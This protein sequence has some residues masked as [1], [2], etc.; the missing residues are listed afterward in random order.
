MLDNIRF[1]QRDR[2][3]LDPLPVIN[4]LSGLIFLLAEHPSPLIST[5]EIISP[6]Y[7]SNG[8]KWTFDIDTFNSQLFDRL[9]LFPIV[10]DA[11]GSNTYFLFASL[12]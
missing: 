11:Y 3:P 2:P 7:P 6:H 8:V 10:T 12:N 5:S 1:E 4:P 9:L